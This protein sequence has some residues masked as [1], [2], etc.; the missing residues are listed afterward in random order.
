MQQGMQ[1]FGLVLFVLFGLLML[2]AGVVLLKIGVWP[3][4]RRYNRKLWIGGGNRSGVPLVHYGSSKHRFHE[5]ALWQS[6][7]RMD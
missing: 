7:C 5:E 1:P 3:R 2:T 4:R 6:V